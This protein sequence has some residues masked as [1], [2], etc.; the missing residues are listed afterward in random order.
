MVLVRGYG[1]VVLGFRL[2]VLVTGF[3]EFFL[4]LY[5]ERRLPVADFR[6]QFRVCVYGCCGSV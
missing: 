6:L 1:I 3:V 5:A 4:L 2:Q